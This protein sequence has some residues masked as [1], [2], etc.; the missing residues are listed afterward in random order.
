MRKIRHD[1]MDINKQKIGLNKSLKN[2]VNDLPKRELKLNHKLRHNIKKI[3][4]SWNYKNSTQ[5]S[6][7]GG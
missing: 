6:I 1:N 5:F 4:E 3:Y 7:S 2:R